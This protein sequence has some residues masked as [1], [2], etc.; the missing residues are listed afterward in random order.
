MLSESSK[1]AAFNFWL[2]EGGEITGIRRA[3]CRRNAMAITVID[4]GMSNVQDS[5]MTVI[6]VERET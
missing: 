5:V 2:A 6:S 1:R 3:M 4:R